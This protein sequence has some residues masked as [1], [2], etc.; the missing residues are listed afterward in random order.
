MHLLTS[1]IVLVM[2]ADSMGPLEAQI[3][4]LANSAMGRSVG[5]TDGACLPLHR[6]RTGVE[7][8]TKGR[9]HHL[10]LQR[11]SAVSRHRG[12]PQ[13]RVRRGT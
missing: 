7:A 6:Q 12:E 1:P 11:V 8:K 10:I 2:T 5:A 13:T 9:A 4:I 3:D